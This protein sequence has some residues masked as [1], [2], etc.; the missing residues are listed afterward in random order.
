M[1]KVFAAPIL[2]SKNQDRLVTWKSLPAF[3]LPAQPR[4]AEATP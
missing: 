1:V 3:W 4:R 2:N